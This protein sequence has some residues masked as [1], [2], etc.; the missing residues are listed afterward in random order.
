MSVLGWAQ[1]FPSLRTSAIKRCSRHGTRLRCSIESFHVPVLIDQVL[2]LYEG[3][4]FEV[5]V[6][7]TIGAGGHASKLLSSCDIDLFIGLDQDEIA[8]A[9]A[10]ERLSK[11]G[12]KVKLVQSSFRDLEKVLSQFAVAQGEV[13]GILLDI[14]VSSMQID[15]A[16]RGFSFISDGPLDMRM[17]RK[18][19]LNAAEVVNNFAVE[20]LTRIF[21]EYGEDPQSRRLAKSVVAFRET[22]QI[23]TTFELTEALLGA[24][25][26][27][28]NRPRGY[29]F[30][31]HPATRVFQA[32]RI[33]VNRE[34]EVLEDSLPSAMKLLR[35]G[36]GRLGVI[37]FHSLE[38]RIVKKA[39]RESAKAIGGVKDLTRK[40]IVPTKEECASNPRSRSAKLRAVERLLEDEEPTGRRNKYKKDR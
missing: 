21:L 9:I 14:G 18:D 25:W 35:P 13:D 31:N 34:L 39:F 3:R 22:K 26:A 27:N 12:D 33:F 30:K 2:E 40:P 17:N 16:D 23:S 28:G 19:G 1:S 6:D 37:T 36:V 7:G 15:T 32:L 24:K 11:Y 29:P 4:R 5:F 8:L 20:E 38:D 10:S